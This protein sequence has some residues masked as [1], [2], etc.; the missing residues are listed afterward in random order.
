MSYSISIG[1]NE[2]QIWILANRYTDWFIEK[3]TDGLNDK[4]LIQFVNKSTYINGVSFDADY[5]EENYLRDKYLELLKQKLQLIM[6]EEKYNDI[7]LLRH[8]EELENL[9]KKT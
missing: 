4:N 6:K 3:L 5:G 2:N 1:K 9:I 8:L 7:E